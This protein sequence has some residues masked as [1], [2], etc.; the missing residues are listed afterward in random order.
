MYPG[1]MTKSY[2]IWWK[3]I[4]INSGIS[5]PMTADLNNSK[6]LCNILI[7]IQTTLKNQKN[8][9]LYKVTAKHQNCHFWEL[10]EKLKRTEKN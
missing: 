5:K 7:P 3:L 2:S 9:L 1:Q 10:K 6:G 4:K 8:T